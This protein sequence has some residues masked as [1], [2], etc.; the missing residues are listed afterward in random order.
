MLQV[1]IWALM[2]SAV[3]G[4]G[5][6]EVKPLPSCVSF[7]P[8]GDLA[9]FIMNGQLEV[10]LAVSPFFKGLATACGRLNAVPKGKGKVHAAPCADAQ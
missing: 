7:Q 3:A 1:L 2:A 8:E 6:P 4:G 5:L 9:G 10:K